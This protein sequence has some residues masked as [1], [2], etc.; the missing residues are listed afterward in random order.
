MRRVDRR[1]LIGGGIGSF[2]LIALVIKS[3]VLSSPPP[4]PPV[5]NSK[6][7]SP[8][9]EPLPSPSPTPSHKPTDSSKEEGRPGPKVLAEVF[10]TGREAGPSA[11]GLVNQTEKSI[12]VTFLNS[13]RC[14]PNSGIKRETAEV[15][16]SFDLTSRKWAQ[17]YRKKTVCSEEGGSGE[18][19][20]AKDWVVKFSPEETTNQFLVETKEQR[21]VITGDLRQGEEVLDKEAV[22][23]V[24]E[25]SAPAPTPTTSP[26]PSTSVPP[27]VHKDEFP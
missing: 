4:P 8:S 14:P 15:E 7:T 25:G 9:T 18:A 22:I 6:V 13:L 3:V 2:L 17:R 23:V 10:L 11:Y 19:K 26:S 1:L 5:S 21:V 12:T 27:E 24:Y 16:Y 20:E